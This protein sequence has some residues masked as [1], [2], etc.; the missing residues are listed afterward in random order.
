MLIGIVKGVALNYYSHSLPFLQPS[1][2]PPVFVS[3]MNSAGF[4]VIECLALTFIIPIIAP[5]N[6]VYTVV[7]EVDTGVIR[8]NC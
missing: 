8:P 7:K 6:E 1:R 2:F 5:V 3:N 4:G